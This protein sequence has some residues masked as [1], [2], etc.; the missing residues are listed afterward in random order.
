M[1]AMINHS[2]L[3]YIP[4]PLIDGNSGG[5]FL[6]TALPCFAIVFRTMPHVQ[7]IIILESLHGFSI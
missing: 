3:W 4:I 1:K 7:K 5:G 6:I 2:Y